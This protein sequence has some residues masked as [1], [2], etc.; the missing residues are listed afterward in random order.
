MR[1]AVREGEAA[2]EEG[3]GV[4]AARS[5]VVL[6]P[7]A[8]GCP[9][10]RASAPCFREIR[11]HPSDVLG[12]PDPHP[13]PKAHIPSPAACCPPA[14]VPARAASCWEQGRRD[15]LQGWDVS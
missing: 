9:H 12:F 3:A 4:R 13:S 2:L 10:T 1:W 11:M 14:H 7:P 8:G 6:N 15:V 5:W